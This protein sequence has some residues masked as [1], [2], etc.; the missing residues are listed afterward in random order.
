MKRKIFI[1]IFAASIVFIFSPAAR[2]QSREVLK[3]D[4]LLVTFGGYFKNLTTLSSY[5]DDESWDNA[6]K[7]RLKTEVSWRG[8]VKLVLHYELSAMLGE[9][10]RDPSFV[11]IASRDPDDFLELYSVIQSSED[12]LAR[13]ML[14]RCYLSIF[15]DS[16]TLSVGRQRIAWGTARFISPTDLF[17]PFDPAEIDKEEKIGVDAAVF[18]I[19]LGGFSGLS[20]VFVPSRDINDASYAFRIYTNIFDYDFSVM[21]GRFR[22][23]EVFGFDF[24][25]QIKGLA[26]F[27]ELAYFIED[28]KDEY[29]V[30]DPLS[31]FGFSPKTSKEE[32][33]RASIGAQYI[34]PN[35]FSVLIEY[36]YNGKGKS[37]KD[38]YNLS[39]LTDG[40]ELTLA[41]DYLF[42]S[43]GYE[44]APL[45]RGDFS[46][47][48][49]IDDE[50]ILFS[51]SVEYS[52][53]EDLYLTIGLQ[54][55]TGDS[56]SEYGMNPDIYFLQM[57]YYF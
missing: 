52:L 53:T 5:G 55:G 45:I 20:L 13:H 37:N 4:D 49:N 7:L 38:D 54:I 40:S 15:F 12:I 8:R 33:F 32:Y 31:P 41:R 2:S 1:T 34:F 29:F 14:D 42:L 27:G 46:A 35:T 43:L 23:K 51:P 21:A 57:R 16:F 50:S 18:E 44:F 47:F 28:T 10:L 48:F 24:A 19:P 39:S 22:D 25:G 56:G 26:V 3:T 17:N 11:D 36:Y 30:T 9:S 6:M